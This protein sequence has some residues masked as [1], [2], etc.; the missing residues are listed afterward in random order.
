MKSKRRFSSPSSRT[1]T[2]GYN[3]R[4]RRRHVRGTGMS[5]PRK[6]WDGERVRPPGWP[7]AMG[8]R[9]RPPTDRFNLRGLRATPRPHLRRIFDAPGGP[10][11]LARSYRVR[12]PRRRRREVSGGDRRHRFHRQGS[13]WQ[14]SASE[15]D[16]QTLRCGCVQSAAAAVRV[17]MSYRLAYSEAYGR[18]TTPSPAT[19]RRQTTRETGFDSP[20][21]KS[22]GTY[23]IV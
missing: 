1:T 11:T 5:R 21:P 14:E 3:C 9:Q 4:F 2:K 19:S 12:H 16:F 7:A 15:R 6:S 22:R 20:R 8:D 18:G 10:I 17:E 13:R 23:V